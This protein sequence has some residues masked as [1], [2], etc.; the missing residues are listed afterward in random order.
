MQQGGNF[1]KTENLGKAPPYSR[2][3]NFSNRVDG[4]RALL[5][6]EREKSPERCQ[7]AGVRTSADV[8]LMTVLEEL[9]DM[10]FADTIRREPWRMVVGDK[11]KKRF[12]IGPVGR[13]G[14]FRQPFLDGKVLKKKP[15]MID[16]A[17]ALQWR[18]GLVEVKRNRSI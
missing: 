15:E 3:F 9:L 5:V 11:S 18:D 1:C 7:P 16:R 13:D 6:E 2:C 10:D 12:Q 4:K 14:I 17:G 8:V